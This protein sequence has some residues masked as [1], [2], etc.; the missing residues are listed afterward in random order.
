MLRE[1]VDTRVRYHTRYL[2]AGKNEQV[3]LE[4]LRMTRAQ[5]ILSLVEVKARLHHATD[6]EGVLSILNQN[7][8]KQRADGVSF[9]RESSYWHNWRLLPVRVIV[10]ERTLRY[11]YAVEPVNYYGEI[12]RTTKRA[13]EFE[14]VVRRDINNAKRYILGIEVNAQ[15]ISPKELQQIQTAAGRLRVHVIGKFPTKY[16][17]RLHYTGDERGEIDHTIRSTVPSYQFGRRL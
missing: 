3:T 6:V 10:D 14:S 17:P 11:N 9:S 2:L 4:W 15:G 12:V 7:K 1:Q 16:D 5:E 13:F 8:F